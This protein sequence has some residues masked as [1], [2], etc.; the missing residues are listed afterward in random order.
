MKPEKLN[1]TNISYV[2]LTAGYTCEI[3]TESVVVTV[4]GAP[5]VLYDVQASN[6]RVV[7]DLAEQGA[8]TGTF[9]LDA[10]IQVDGFTD[11]GAVGGP[12]KVYVTIR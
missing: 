12:Y 2:N 7:V 3:D 4:R 10:K 1:A 8:A 5:D 9:E 11:V 6:I